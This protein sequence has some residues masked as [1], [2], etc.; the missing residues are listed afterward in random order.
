MEHPP[1]LGVGPH[2]VQGVPVGIPVVDDGGQVQLLGEGELGVKEVPGV[3]PVL[4]GLDPVVVQAD[5]PHRHAFGVGAEG[6]DLRQVGQGGPLQVLRVEPGGKVE[7]GV[8]FGQGHA[9]PGGLQIA[10]GANHP[11]YPM[12]GEGGEHLVPV[13]GKMFVVIVGMS[14]E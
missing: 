8:F 12:G 3:G 4:G 7:E 5:L 14:V 2:D 6:L 10:A 9:L 13:G 11:L 1:G